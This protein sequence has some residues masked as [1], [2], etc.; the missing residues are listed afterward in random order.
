MLDGQD[1]SRGSQEAT[2]EQAASSTNSRAAASKK[3]SKSSSSRAP[4]THSTAAKRYLREKQ[5]C[6]PSFTQAL[7][8]QQ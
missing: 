6:K 4:K 3:E 8:H 5:D 1:P 7:F 2:D